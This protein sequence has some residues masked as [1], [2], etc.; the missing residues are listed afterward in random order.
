M[1][2]PIRAVAFLLLSGAVWTADV[3]L[4]ETVLPRRGSAQE[5]AALNGGETE[6]AS[7]R[8]NEH[9]KD[10]VTVG[11][12]ALTLGIFGLCIGTYRGRPRINYVTDVKGGGQL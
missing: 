12:W 8:S 1:N 3:W 11:A 2:L 7:V 5:I 9:V 4:N 6:V 10:A